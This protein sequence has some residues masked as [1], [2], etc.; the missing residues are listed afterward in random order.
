MTN[1]ISDAFD[2]IKMNPQLKESTKQV[3]SEKRNR[4]SVMLWHPAVKRA[5]RTVCAALLLVIGIGGYSFFQTPVSYVSIDVNP[6]IELAL[7]RW[8]RVV[9]ATA[10][11]DEGEGI[12]KN[13]SLNW[14]LY[15]DAIDEVVNCK[16]MQPYL[17]DAAELFF[18]VAAGPERESKI[19]TEVERYIAKIKKNCECNSTKDISV[20]GLAHKHQLS[21]GKYY[22]YLELCKYDDTITMNDCRH[23]SMSEMHDL[24]TKHKGNHGQGENKKNGDFVEKHH[25]TEKPSVLETPQPQKS[26]SCQEPP[27]NN[28]C[29]EPQKS[30]V[31]QEPP[32]NNSYQE[33]PKSEA[34]QEPPKNN[35]Y[36]EPQKS[37]AYLEP[38]KNNSCQQPPKNNSCQQP[39]KNNSCQQ[40]QKSAVCQEPQKSAVCQQ[41]QKS[42]SCQ[43][44]QDELHHSNKHKGPHHW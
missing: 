24:M 40:P 36:Q 34:C 44:S 39:P 16:E 30:A 32:Q 6:S 5:I 41:P 28:S 31:C 15:T 9:S 2:C 14:K 35:P 26:E 37:E 3:L 27:E 21:L 25:S 20:V 8:N 17:T 22:L 1:K 4:R 29:Q 11:N 12:L 13:L 42:S 23:M 43:Q 18:T 38:P 33:P 19:R 7:N 10:Y